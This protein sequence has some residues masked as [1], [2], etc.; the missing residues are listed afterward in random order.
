MASQFDRVP[1]IMVKKAWQSCGCN[2]LGLHRPEIRE[3]QPEAEPWKSK[4]HLL[5]AYACH[6]GPLSQRF[7]NL[8]DTP[9]QDRDQGFKFISLWGSFHGQFL[10]S[11]W[12][13]GSVNRKFFSYV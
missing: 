5:R 12:R 6:I 7:H 8:Q 11:D 4:I 13:V 10:T 9:M 1:S 2:F 3:L